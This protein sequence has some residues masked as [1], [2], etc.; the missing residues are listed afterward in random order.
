MKEKSGLDMS[1][2]KRNLLL[3]SY[4][5][6]L[7]FIIGINSITVVEWLNRSLFVDFS[8]D[9][10][11]M[12]SSFYN[13]VSVV[14]LIMILMYSIV[15]T[16][17]VS[18]LITNLLLGAFIVANS[19]KVNERNEYITFSELQAITSPKELLS[20]ID[21]S[22]WFALLMFLLLTISLVGLQYIIIKVS[23]KMN[24]QVNKKIRIG[25]FIVSIIP[26]ILI[27]SQ[28]N[29]YNKHVLKYEESNIHN[30][31]PVNRARLDGFLP[32]F[33]HTVKPQYMDKSEQY[34]KSNVKEI[35]G[36]Y[37]QV[38]REINEGRDKSL[39]D[40][41]TILYLSESLID[42][43]Q[44]PNLLL[45]ETPLPFISDI[46]EEN[47]GGTMYSQYVGGG[48]ANI[49]WSVLTSF[50]LEVFR[51]PMAITPYSDF[52]TQSKNHNTVLSLYD[53]EKV[54][55]H[56]YSAH[57]YK[58]RSVYNA[59]GFDE[60]LYLNNGIEHTEKLGTHKRVSDESLN[61]DILRVANNE[62]VGLIHALTMQNHSP[63]SGVIEEMTYKPEINSDVFPKKDQEGL[64]NYLQGLK[65]TDDAVKELITELEKSDKDVNVLLYGDHFPSLFRG[66]EDQFTDE[67]IHETPWFIYMNDGR[68][69]KGTQLDGLSPAFLITVLL[70]EG[71]YYVTPF[72]GLMDELLTQG[73]KR[74]GNDFIVTKDGKLND[75]E[76]SDDLLMMINDY[77]IIQYDAL[78]G[79]NWLSDSFFTISE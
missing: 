53:K 70:R 30:W 36:K 4:F 1:K 79:S 9:L 50:S 46:T 35:S 60:F 75:S 21:V 20:F 52:Y 63:Y 17:I 69:E 26:L 3:I 48:T 10:E 38:A 51:E 49:E 65:A 59:I 2:V 16:F 23:K 67:E 54:A 8:I 40:S 28:P 42:P 62:D 68:S 19:I 25:L 45:N 64:F 78:F 7:T 22:V 39:N 32:S 57:L 37:S 41:Q 29:L 13:G 5:L 77:R 43:L 18:I 66:L 27:F 24:F 33:L 44:L 71:N 15:G 6:L 76:L 14:F 47:S 55:I 72:Q 56:P 61:K 74:I 31:N 58:R 73:V 34:S 11:Q 12:N